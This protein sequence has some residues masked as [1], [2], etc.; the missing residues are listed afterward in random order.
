M[1]SFRIGGAEPSAALRQF[2][3]QEEPQVNLWISRP[4]DPPPQLPAGPWLVVTEGV[5]SEDQRQR[6]LAALDEESSLLEAWTPASLRRALK[7]S[8]LD[9]TRLAKLYAQGGRALAD[10]MVRNFL[11]HS[12][13]LLQSAQ[14]EWEGDRDGALRRLQRLHELAGGVGASEL[15]ELLDQPE[16]DWER[17]KREL[18][19]ARRVFDNQHRQDRTV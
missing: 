10:H 19:S 15:Q 14:A 18:E 11:Q 7:P 13:G 5:L 9:S 17:L 16:P 2:L 8:M 6:W 1:P 4:G 3:D 12:P